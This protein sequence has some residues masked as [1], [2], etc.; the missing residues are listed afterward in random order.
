M[1]VVGR[2]PGEAN[3]AAMLVQAEALCAGKKLRLT[4]L[5]R[6]VLEL[7]LNAGGPIKAYDLLERL[8]D[9]GR[10]NPATIY[11]AL[12]F[13]MSANLVCKIVT[14]NA[15]LPCIGVQ[16]AHGVAVYICQDCGSVEHRTDT[17]TPASQPAGFHVERSFV[18]HFGKC[19]RC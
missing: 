15:F 19:G 2:K 6:R 18:E 13:L 7:M 10:A 1:S 14:M 4:P 11:R 5:R 17:T 3:I 9:R 8:R 12:D 16:P